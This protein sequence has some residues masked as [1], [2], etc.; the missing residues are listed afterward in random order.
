MLSLLAMF[1]ASVAHAQSAPDLTLTGVLTEADHQTYREVPFDVPAGVTSL[2]VEFAY[3]GREQKAVI[4]LG[5]RDPQRFRGWS[6]GNKTSFAVAETYATASYLP[7]PLPAGQWRLILGVPNLRKGQRAEYVAKVSFGRDA[8]FRGFA[9]A[10]LKTAPGWYRG[11]LHLHTGDSD[12][13]CASHS[14]V[15]APCPM[16]KTL[17][18]AVAGGLDFVV[19]TE[20]N[21]TSHHQGLA[22][23]QPHFDDLLLIPG[24]EI[25]TFQGHAGVWGPVAP[26]DFQ[27]GGLR[28]P[29]F[30]A[31]AAQAHQAGGMV[32]I[33]HPMLPSGELC[34]GCGWTAKTDYAGVD[35]VEVVNGATL[36]QTRSDTVFSGIPFWEARLNEGWRLTAVGGSDNH[37]ATRPAKEAGAVG[38]PTTVVWAE[39][40]SQPAIL[41][42]LKS[43]RVF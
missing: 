23:L 17:E 41:A 25:T 14:G 12:G 37:D 24:R 39:A 11:D 9:A 26:I 36:A 34:M 6:G 8:D 21:A 28:A 29:E 43:G 27:L 7:G 35:A 19:V 15:A 30:A 4:D 20:H 38:R 16:F 33:N 3:T 2:S 42:G 5:L 18:A 1:A 32:A 31:I 13:Y 22:G 40:L 10:P